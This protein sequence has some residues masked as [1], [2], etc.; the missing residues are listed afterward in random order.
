MRASVNP[1]SIA[2]RRSPS[3]GAVALGAAPVGFAG[4]IIAVRGAE[5]GAL[6]ATETE[7]RLVEL[8]FV[9]GARVEVLHQGLFGGDPIAVRIDTAT[10]ALRR[11]E[12][13][14]ILVRPTAREPS[15]ALAA[16]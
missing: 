7:R 12:A 10:I 4:E 6:G 3:H 15:I 13:A 16:E 1:G 5:G 2:S 11:R 9:E 14:A 8:G